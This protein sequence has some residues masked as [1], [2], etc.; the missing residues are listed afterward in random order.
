M[1]GE[2]ELSFEY[3]VRD[4][5]ERAA[6]GLSDNENGVLYSPTV[7][8]APPA[9]GAAADAPNSTTPA[10]HAA[11]EASLP[12]QVR[13]GRGGSLVPFLGTLH[14]FRPLRGEE[15]KRSS[16]ASVMAGWRE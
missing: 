9:A 5:A 2:T 4:K 8:V 13:L 6:L 15:W 7:Q 12:F 14:R 1:T 16:V 3:Q 10:A 11:V